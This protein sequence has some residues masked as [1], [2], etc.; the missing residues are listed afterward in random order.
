MKDESKTKEQ[1]ASELTEL[2]RQ[3]AQFRESETTRRQ[4]DE[5]L[6]ENEERY[7]LLFENANDAI[8]LMREDG[9]IECNPKTLDMFGC[10]KEQILG[11]PPY[12][13]SPPLQPDGRDSREKALE[14]ARAAIAGEPQFFDW[15]HC[16][17][18]GTLFD[19]EVSL[20]AV[21][22]GG[23]KLTQAIVRD[24]TERKRSERALQE[25]EEL[26]RAVVESVADGIAVTVG[27]ERV[28]V[29]KGFLEIHG[30]QDASPVLGLPLDQF[31]LPEDREVVK[32]RVLA[33]LER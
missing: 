12:S 25:S 19:A 15:K 1:V 28:F 18:D 2:R 13:F 24:I 32:E 10:T 11:K 26:H 22:L 5:I 27:T 8:F 3:I 21:Q 33:R 7:R 16:R 4:I 29:N 14:K 20:N 9:F 6:R 30:L 31:I 23:K 17:Y